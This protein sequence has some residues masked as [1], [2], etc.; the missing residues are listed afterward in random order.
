[1]IKKCQQWISKVSK[2]GT[3]WQLVYWPT[4][5]YHLGKPSMNTERK[6]CTWVERFGWIRLTSLL[7]FYYDNLK[8]MCIHIESLIHVQCTM[9]SSL[10][11]IHV[12]ALNEKSHPGEATQSSHVFVKSNYVINAPRSDKVFADDKE[13]DR[14]FSARSF[15]ISHVFNEFTCFALLN[16]IFGILQTSYNSR[17]SYELNHAVW[18]CNLIEI[19][20]ASE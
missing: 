11:N 1:M 20:S 10:V 6:R 3:R 8:E 18:S 14:S 19:P 5:F 2:L 7:V 16:S 4:I 15:S 13:L 17:A 12:S 9:L